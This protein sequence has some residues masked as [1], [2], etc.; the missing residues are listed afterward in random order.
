MRDPDFEENAYVSFHEWI[1]EIH[2][3]GDVKSQSLANKMTRI[4]SDDSLGFTERYEKLLTLLENT[5]MEEISISSL[6]VPGTSTQTPLVSEFSSEALRGSSSSP[7]PGP[8]TDVQPPASTSSED[9]DPVIFSSSSPSAGSPS[10]RPA[11]PG[12]ESPKKRKG[13][14]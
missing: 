2:R 14:A 7:R 11:G 6:P 5:E 13:T 1:T 8:S 9:V 12:G 4:F 3:K 10:K